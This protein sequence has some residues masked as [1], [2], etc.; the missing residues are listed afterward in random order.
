MPKGLSVPKGDGPKPTKRKS[1]AARRTA[2]AHLCLKADR[3][4]F[5]SVPKGLSEKEADESKGPLSRC[6]VAPKGPLLS[7]FVQHLKVQ[8]PPFQ[9]D[10]EGQR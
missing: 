5:L 4:V 7:R 2:R 10:S 1:K 6:V 9:T 3:E 8:P